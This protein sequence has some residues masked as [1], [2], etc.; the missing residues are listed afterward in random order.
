MIRLY[1]SGL[2]GEPIETHVIDT[3]ILLADWLKQQAPD[4]SLDREHPIC[5]KVG[6]A[7]LP[8]EAWA[9]FVVR[10]DTDVRIYPEP[11]ASALVVAAWAAVAVAAVALV[12]VL[13][14]KTPGVSQPGQGDSMDLNPAKANRAKVNE[15]VR[16]ILGRYKV[17]PD[18]VVQ[19]VSRFVNQRELHTSL[20]LCVGAGSHSILPSSIKIGDTPLAAFGADVSYAF[21][22]P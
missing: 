7:L 15:P 11:R 4:F 6:G 17:Y 21:Y 2:E 3:P 22:G 20:C 10:P 18:Y 1:P 13:S 16:E 5:I 9:D 14:M 8:V 12:M 19:P